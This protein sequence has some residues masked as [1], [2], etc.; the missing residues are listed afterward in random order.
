MN[1]Y[2]KLAVVTLPPIMLVRMVSVTVTVTLQLLS[3][4]CFSYMRTPTDWESTIT[5]WS[6]WKSQASKRRAELSQWRMSNMS[7]LPCHPYERVKE[8]VRQGLTAKCNTLAKVNA[9]DWIVDA[10]YRRLEDN[11]YCSFIFQQ[12]GNIPHGMVARS[13]ENV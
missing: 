13:I 9:I 12:H 2:S 6:A 10:V 1:C 5:L 8:L 7:D 4:L 3:L 11:R